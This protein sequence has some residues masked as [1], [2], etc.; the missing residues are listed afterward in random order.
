MIHPE[1]IEQIVSSIW[2]SILNLP[3][4]PA[5]GVALEPTSPQGRMLR[6]VHGRFR[7]RHTRPHDLGPRAPIGVG[8]VRRR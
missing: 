3:I 8:D 1:E 2:M 4:V 7:G 5:E 6:S